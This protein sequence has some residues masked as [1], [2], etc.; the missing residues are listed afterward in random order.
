MLLYG[1]VIFINILVMAN[2]ALQVI[3]GDVMCNGN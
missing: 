3:D 2:W 1:I